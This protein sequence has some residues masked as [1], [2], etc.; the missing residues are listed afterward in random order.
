MGDLP[1]LEGHPSSVPL[2]LHIV[3]VFCVFT[4]ESLDL[5]SWQTYDVLYSVLLVNVH[6][7]EEVSIL[8]HRAA[9]AKQIEFYVEN[10]VIKAIENSFNFL[11][12]TLNS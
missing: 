11:I 2:V 7:E 1:V 3:R 4:F 12:R 6:V 9:P 5:V 10:I 8:T